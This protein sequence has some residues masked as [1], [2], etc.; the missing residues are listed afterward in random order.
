MFTATTV[1]V[2]LV[3]ASAATVAVL[4]LGVFEEVASFA[5]ANG[6][7][8]FSLDLLL[9]A[10]LGNLDLFG[11]LDDLSFTATSVFALTLVLA[12]VATEAI[13]VL[14]LNKVA[15]VAVAFTKVDDFVRLL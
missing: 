13:L 10:G 1:T 6:A 2:A 8:N 3:V 12:F 9:F 7:D 5:S 15:S 4:L 11:L 14:V